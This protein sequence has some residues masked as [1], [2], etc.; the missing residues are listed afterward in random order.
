VTG[1]SLKISASR[2][3]DSVRPGLGP[4]LL[5]K[6]KMTIENLDEGLVWIKLAEGK[7]VHA[8]NWL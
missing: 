1:A 8:L 4:E 3:L 7:D 6:Q 2:L 5:A